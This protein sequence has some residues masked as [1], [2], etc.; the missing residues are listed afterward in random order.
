MLLPALVL[1]SSIARGQAPP[2]AATAPGPSRPAELELERSAAAFALGE[3]EWFHAHPELANQE[4]ET[5]A[6]LATALEGMGA[7]VWRGVGGTGIVALLEGEKPG[8]KVTVLY[9]ADMD[10]LPVTERTELPYRSQTPGVTHACG[11]DLHMATAL[12]AL[13]TLAETR[14]DW[15]GT[16]L[17]IGQPA[18]EVSGGAKQM[19]AEAGSQNLHPQG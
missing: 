11:H 5:A 13:R 3:Y 4:R 9:R 14:R 18:E 8:P 15:S 10:G 16:V 19:L 12:G 17:F 2:A 6:R 1:C 7:K